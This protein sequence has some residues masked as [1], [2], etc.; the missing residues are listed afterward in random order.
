MSIQVHLILIF[1]RLG[2]PSTRPDADRPLGERLDLLLKAFAAPGALLLGVLSKI[3][4]ETK[5]SGSFN[6]DLF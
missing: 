3:V 2:R 6:L 1:G 4:E 5:G